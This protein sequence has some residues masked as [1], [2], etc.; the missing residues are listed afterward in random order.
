MIPPR[1]LLVAV[2]CLGAGSSWTIASADL[3]GSSGNPKTSPRQMRPL[4]RSPLPKAAGAPLPGGAQPHAMLAGPP[5]D[6]CTAPTTLVGVGSFPFDNTSATTSIEGQTET[7]CNMYSST[8]LVQDLWFQ[9]TALSSGCAIFETCGSTVDTKIALY[10]GTGCPVAG[11]AIDC[12]DDTCG[13]QTRLRIFATAGVTYTI[14]L[15]LYPY[16]AAPGAG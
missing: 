15:G 14:Q 9:W 7:L 6:D 1:R 8:A 3:T 5:N 13:V 12:D 16:G 10:A 4:A 11:T 2:A